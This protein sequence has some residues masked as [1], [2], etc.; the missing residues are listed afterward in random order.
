MNATNKIFQ[1][2]RVL[3]VQKQ[4]DE[5]PLILEQIVKGAALFMANLETNGG[6][7]NDHFLKK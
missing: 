2:P 1:L 3:K 4:T 5:T 6:L 7:I